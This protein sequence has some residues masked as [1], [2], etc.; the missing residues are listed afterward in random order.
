M[1]NGK[2]DDPRPKSVSEEEW[3]RRYDLINWGK[4]NEPKQEE[5]SKVHD[6]YTVSMEGQCERKVLAE[7]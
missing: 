3:G 6:V 1:S 7:G 4:K 5:K 2:G